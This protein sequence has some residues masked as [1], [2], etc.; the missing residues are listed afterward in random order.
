MAVATTTPT[1]SWSRRAAD[2][3][4]GALAELLDLHLHPAWRVALAASADEAAAEAA[5]VDRRV[6]R[7]RSPPPATPSRP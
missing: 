4:T 3:D 5:V 2:G 6:R 7:P 1:R